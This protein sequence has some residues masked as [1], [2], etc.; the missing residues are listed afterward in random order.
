MDIGRTFAQ[1]FVAGHFFL[2]SLPWHLESFINCLKS[3]VCHGAIEKVD[4]VPPLRSHGGDVKWLEMSTQP[5]ILPSDGEL[6]RN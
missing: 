3:P 6:R 5:E 2:K 1:N 4:V